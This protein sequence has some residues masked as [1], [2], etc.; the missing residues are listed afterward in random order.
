MS[1]T[2]VDHL[3]NLGSQGTTYAYEG[4]K[5]EILETFK[6]PAP[7]NDY[8]VEIE[9]PEMSSLCPRTGQPDFANIVIKYKPRAVCVESK[10]LKLYFFAWRNEGCFMEEITNRICSDLV[11]VLDPDWLVVEGRFNPRG[12]MKLWPIAKYRRP[13]TSVEW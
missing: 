9:F 11:A 8:T 2:P 10:S 4:P 13:G 6:N 1:Q 7:G 3:K 12:G 5:A